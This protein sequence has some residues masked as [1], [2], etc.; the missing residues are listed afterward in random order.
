MPKLKATARLVEPLG[1]DTLVR[2]TQGQHHI[3]VR[4]DGQAEV[5]DGD[6][7]NIGFDAAR[8]NIFDKHT[9]ERL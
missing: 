4:I 3:W 9:E 6:E 5:A 8:A 1:S 7:L 2:A